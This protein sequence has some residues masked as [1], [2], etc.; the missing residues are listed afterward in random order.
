[1]R[2]ERSQKVS[3]KIKSQLAFDLRQVHYF[4]PHKIYTIRLPF[5]EFQSIYEEWENEDLPSF[6]ESLPWYLINSKWR[7]Q[8]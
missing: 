1:M 8:R 7:L 2:Y 3:P 6:E 5:K 4:R